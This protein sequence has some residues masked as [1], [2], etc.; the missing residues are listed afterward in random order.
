[1]IA[2]M[3]PAGNSGRPGTGA[4]AA[5]SR[6]VAGWRYSNGH[7]DLRL[8]LLRGFAAFAMI[9][10]HIGGEHSWLFALTGGNRFFVS[11]AEAFV[12]ISGVVMGMVYRN[13]VVRQGVAA[14]LMKALGRAWTLYLVTVFLTLTFAYL[15]RRFEL[16]WAPDISN[17]GVGRF[18]LDVFTLHRTLFLVDIPMMYAILLLGAAPMILLLSQGHTWFVLLA[19]WAVWLIWQISP[20]SGSIPWAIEGNVVFNIAAWQVL[21]V[22]GI[23][24]GWHRNMIEGAVARVPQVLVK[25][26]LGLSLLAVAVM[27]VLQLTELDSLTRSETV[28]KLLFDKGDVPIGRLVVFAVLA[29]ASF[30]L[31]TV[32]W[33]PLHRLTGWLLLPLG[34]NSL[35]AYS[36]HVFLVALTAK[37]AVDYLGSIEDRRAVDTLLQL[38]GV[39]AVWLVVVLEPPVRKWLTDLA[40]R[41]HGGDRAGTTRPEGSHA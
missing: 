28:Y 41:S 34:Q 26:A 35:T 25:G 33:R 2:A 37:L 20:E 16:W 14:A 15:G 38:G 24:I 22:T 5:A 6:R 31:T 21:F 30:T 40:S 27:L 1:M 29:T 3:E 18:V 13:V 11:A 9:A 7:R 39:L 8:D 12:F 36:L 23:V 19:S 32:L 4:I 17:G 10:D